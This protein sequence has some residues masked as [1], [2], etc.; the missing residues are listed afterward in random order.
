MKKKVLDLD[1][2]ME[3]RFLGNDINRPFFSLNIGNDYYDF[4]TVEELR[5][6]RHRVIALLDKAVELYDDVMTLKK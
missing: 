4:E 2:D 1:I 5:E 6:F 3:T